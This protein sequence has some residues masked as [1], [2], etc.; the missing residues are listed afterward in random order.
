MSG[1]VPRP[2]INGTDIMW[3]KGKCL[4]HANM[5][6]NYWGG[7]PYI[8]N[9]NEFIWVMP[10]YKSNGTPVPDQTIANTRGTSLAKLDLLDGKSM[11]QNTM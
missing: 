5:V 1:Q 8:N 3:D 2:R 11:H 6:N 7:Y 10:R 4:T 9:A